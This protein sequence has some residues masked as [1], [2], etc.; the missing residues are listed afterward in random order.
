MCAPLVLRIACRGTKA[1]HINISIY[2]YFSKMLAGRDYENAH[3]WVEI[4][5]GGK[6]GKKGGGVERPA[7]AEIFPVRRYLGN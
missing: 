4:E 3:G 1:P 6:S 7:L 5:L 2:Q